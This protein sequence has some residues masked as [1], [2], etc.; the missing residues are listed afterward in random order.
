MTDDL[1]NVNSPGTGNVSNFVE[2]KEKRKN[3]RQA[4][5]QKKDDDDPPPPKPLAAE[6]YEALFH[7]F[8]QTPVLGKVLPVPKFNIKAYELEPGIHQAMIVGEG[9]ECQPVNLSKI[10]QMIL[11]YTAEDLASI[12]DYRFTSCQAGAAAD[13]WSDRINCIQKPASTLFKNAPGNCFRRIPFDLL[14]NPNGRHTPLFNEMFSRIKSN[15][16]ALRAYIW[17]LLI[18]ESFNQQYV[19]LYGAGNDGKGALARTLLRLFGPR[20][21]GSQNTAPWRG[22]KHWAIP[23]IDKR[24]VVFPDFKDNSSMDNGILKSLT[25]GDDVYVDPKG[26]KG[27]NVRLSAKLIFCSN[28]MPR[29]DPNEYEIR[30]LILAEFVSTT[31]FDAAYEEKLWGEMPYF[32]SDCKEVYERL[33]PNHEKIPIDDESKES[34]SDSAEDRN[35]DLQYVFD[36]HFEIK[37]SS[38]LT[39]KEVRDR[40]NEAGHRDTFFGQRFNDWLANR[41]YVP[42]RLGRGGTRQFHGLKL[43]PFPAKTNPFS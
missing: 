35:P 16:T 33:C 15:G 2:E 37:P 21:S 3:K 13:Y 42:K 8:E 17:S 40:L 27:Y 19:W 28:H 30:R 34:I 5:P 25:G 6:L 12:P 36:H 10:R 38:R 14:P 32:L 39:P 20:I 18:Q 11:R 24:L 7:T 31:K 22:N 26:T 9:G 23:F 4:K 1:D 43:R 41:G 29:V